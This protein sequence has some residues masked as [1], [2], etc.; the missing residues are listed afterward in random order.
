MNFIGLGYIFCQC[1]CIDGVG[2]KEI[3][4]NMFSDRGKKRKNTILL[5]FYPSTSFFDDSVDTV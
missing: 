2:R 3:N 4:L 5:Y 1:K